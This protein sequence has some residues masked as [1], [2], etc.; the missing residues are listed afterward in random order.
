M[1]GPVLVVEALE[2]GLE[3]RDRVLRAARAHERV[4]Q[5]VHGV[6]AGV[7]RGRVAAGLHGEYFS[8]P[9]LKPPRG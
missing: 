8:Y 9:G 1:N 4:A 3:N 6:G 2:A 5:V 7:D